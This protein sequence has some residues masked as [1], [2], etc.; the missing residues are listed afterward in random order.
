MDS[1]TASCWKRFNVD[2][3]RTALGTLRRFLR[4]GTLT[5]LQLWKLYSV[6]RPRMTLEYEF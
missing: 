4:P 2:P 6:N 1:L 5:V 3:V